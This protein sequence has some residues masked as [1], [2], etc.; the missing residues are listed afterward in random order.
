MTI[1]KV[2][3]KMVAATTAAANLH[4]QLEAL[5]VKADAGG[6]ES[7]DYKVLKD[8]TDVA[9]Y[10]LPSGFTYVDFFDGLNTYDTGAIDYWKVEIEL[11]ELYVPGTVNPRVLLTD[12]DGAI[13]G[14][15][16][17]AIG[18]FTELVDGVPFSTGGQPNSSSRFMG[19]GSSFSE[20]AGS[21]YHGRITFLAKGDKTAAANENTLRVWIDSKV[22]RR[23]SATASNSN[24][25]LNGCF[26]ISVSDPVEL[27]KLRF[28]PSFSSTGGSIKMRYRVTK[29]TRVDFV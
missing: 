15:S 10:N 2:D 4:E 6:S 27:V 24:S 13:V 9:L 1:E 20:E 23:S 19:V 11:E 29:T 17:P 16:G 5:E 14:V 26:G 21:I 7:A 28:A 8:W 3:L 25:I 22:L 12:T 18:A